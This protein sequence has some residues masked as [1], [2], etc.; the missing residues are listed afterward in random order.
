MKT[1]IL[2]VGGGPVGLYLQYRFLRLGFDSL[3]IEQ[4]NGI[5]HHSKSIGIHPVIL[6][7]FAKCPTGSGSIAD[8]W[9]DAGIKIRKGIAFWNQNRIGEVRFDAQRRKFDAQQR[10]FDFI[11]ALPQWET[12]R[13]LEDAVL[14]LNPE[15]MLRGVKAISM[16]PSMHW[17]NTGEVVVQVRTETGAGQ[18]VEAGLQAEA[19]QQ[20]K[21]RLQV[22]AGQQVAAGQQAGA[23]QQFKKYQQEGTRQQS[24]EHHAG[25]DQQADT[26]SARETQIEI[27]AQL[28]IACDGKHGATREWLG[29]SKT[30][31]RYPDTYIMGDFDDHT[32]FG[33]DA[34]V[35]LHRDG[36]VESFPLPGEKRRWVVK[37]DS[38]CEEQPE[39]LLRSLLEERLQQDPGSQNADRVSAFRVQHE[40]AAEFGRGRV[41]LAGDSAHVV[42][43]IGGQGMNLGWLGAD[44]LISE[45]MAL[46]G[47]SEEVLSE[48]WLATLLSRYEN[49]H[50]K[51]ALQ[52]GKRAEWNMRMGRR[53]SHKPWVE[54]ILK[55]A[56]RYRKTNQLLAD[57]FTMRGLGSWPV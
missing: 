5:S 38:F 57:L 49:K 8:R 27:R 9:I 16:E 46:K 19:G 2:I 15:S 24:G 30:G 50:R 13:V 34:A 21:A 56:L 4:R 43:P 44:C 12:E 23:R 32:S 25:D 51:I 41:F 11:L 45:M 36:L 55:S 7:S 6:E 17:K 10:R 33:T 39:L 47:V 26:K 54:A 48:P 31:V 3:L 29:I 37:T 28:V 42:S 53:E 22:E 40:I 14:E 52:V 18:Q 1:Q 35:Y 20:V